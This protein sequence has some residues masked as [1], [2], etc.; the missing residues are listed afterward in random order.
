M[1]YFTYREISMEGLSKRELHCFAMC[2]FVICVVESSFRLFKRCGVQPKPIVALPFVFF[3]FPTR[4][5]EITQIQS[6][7]GTF[8]HQVENCFIGEN[9]NQNAYRVQGSV[10]L[11]AK[12][13]RRVKFI[14]VF[15]CRSS[16][17]LGEIS[18]STLKEPV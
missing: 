1:R 13:N 18:L 11:C 9:W 8:R 6:D 4:Q 7:P 10:I 12:L 16:I 14:Y 3:F 15:H 2:R 5:N 17:S